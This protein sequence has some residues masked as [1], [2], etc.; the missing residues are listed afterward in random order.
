MFA[1]PVSLRL[2][3]AGLA[4]A[5]ILAA[6]ACSEALRA[7]NTAAH[8]AVTPTA[9]TIEAGSSVALSATITNTSGERL[10]DRVVFWNTGDTDVATVSQRGVVSGRRPG[11]TLVAASCDGKSAVV[12]VT[13]VPPRVASV[14]VEPSKAEIPVGG[15]A[16]L[17][18]I[19]R[20]AAGNPLT[21]RPIAWS[22]SNERVATVDAAG[23]VTAH[24]PG[25]AIVSA[26]SEGETG[27]AD[28][29]VRPPPPDA[30]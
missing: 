29:L 13:V 9:A 19:T 3:P 23:V 21:G 27:S 1:L 5:A 22:T 17:A 30:H 7:A 28:V 24:D 14:T 15:T 10:D 20:D 26:T 18:A 8:I 6:A 4:V 25:S 11:A 2:A 16:H 12:S